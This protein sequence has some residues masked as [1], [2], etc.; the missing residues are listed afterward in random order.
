MLSSNLTRFRNI[1]DKLRGGYWFLPMIMAVLAVLAAGLLLTIDRIYFSRSAVEVVPDTL[2]DTASFRHL[3]TLVATS[4]LAFL[5]VLFSVILV[6]LSI[7]AGQLG[8]PVMRTFLRNTGTQ[9]VLGLFIGNIF[10]SLTLLAAVPEWR[11]RPPALSSVILLLMFMASIA[12]LLYFINEVAHSLQANTVITRLSTEL[13]DDIRLEM[14]RAPATENDFEQLEKQRKEILENGTILRAQTEGYIRAIDY[15]GLLKLAVS[16]KTTLAM[17]FEPGDFIMRGDKLV[18]VPVASHVDEALVDQV[19]RQFL[20]GSYRTITQDIDFGLLALVSV[21]VRALSPA[22]ND[23]F[24]ANLCLQRL[25]AALSMIAERGEKTHHYRD[26]AGVVRL[27]GEPDTFEEHANMC[28]HQIRQYGRASTEVLI[29]MLRTIS[30]VAERTRTEAQR[31]VLRLHADLIDRQAHTGGLTEYD[32]TRVR[33][34]YEQTI[35]VIDRLSETKDEAGNRHAAKR[36]PK[37]D[38]L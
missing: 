34:Q 29:T 1:S 31:T 15:D 7:A 22:I 9:V 26:K 8:P 21:A 4:T 32:A 35:E 12:A 3:A 5:G 16:Y 33:L 11:P 19:N 24:T 37:D 36:A 6:P 20:M 27:L 28:F 13:E 14:S 17:H 38:D 18:C 23:P 10:F 25:G 30:R 2:L